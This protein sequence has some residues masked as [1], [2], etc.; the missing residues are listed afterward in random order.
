[1]HFDHEDWDDTIFV[2]GSEPGLIVNDVVC[3]TKDSMDYSMIFTKKE[4]L[5]AVLYEY[6]MD[7]M[8][9]DGRFQSYMGRNLEQMAE[10]IQCIK[11][12]GGMFVHVHPFGKGGYYDPADPMNYWFADGT[13]FE[14]CNSLMGDYSSSM[15]LKAYECWVN[16]LNAGKRIWATSGTDSHTLPTGLFALS[17]LYTEQRNSQGYFDQMRVGNL[18]AGPAGVRITVGDAVT[19]SAGSFAGNRVVIAA[20]DFHVSTINPQY[21]YRLDIY[22]ETGLISSQPISTTEMNYFAFDADPDAMYYRA[23]IYDVTNNRIYAVGN[24][25]WN[26]Q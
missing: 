3:L 5:E 22:D 24:P 25:V 8:Y 4:G 6:M 12:N 19:G 13:G 17:T 14:V 2:G 21:K 10:L 11:D 26:D 23:N 15:N 16:L 18:T 1:M 9:F 7:Y 20:G